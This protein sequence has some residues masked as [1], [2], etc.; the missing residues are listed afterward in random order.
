MYKLYYIG[1]KD[2]GIRKSDLEGKTQFLF[3]T[4]LNLKEN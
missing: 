2:I 3:E 1:W 4:W